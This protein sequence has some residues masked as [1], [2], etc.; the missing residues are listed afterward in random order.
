MFHS[1]VRSVV[2]IPGI[3]FLTACGGGGSSKD[4]DSTAQTTPVSIQFSAVVG[5]EPLACNVDYNAVGTA[6]TTTQ[7][8]DFRLFVHGVQLITDS[9]EAVSLT[10]DSSVW[11]AQ[12]VALLDF[13]NATGE[14]TGTAE[15]NVTVTGIV[16]AT[17]ASFTGVRFT[18]GIPE[19][20]NHLEQ[21]SVSPF[22]VTGM[23]W[24]W[25]NG[26]KFI[27]F[28]VPNWNVHVG[29]TGCAANGSGNVVCTHANRPLIELDNFDYQSQSI[30]IDYAAL[31]QGSD[32]S[33]DA[34]GATGCMS[35]GT[36]PEC[37]DVFTQLGLN[38][39]SGE[40]D[41]ALTQSVFSVAD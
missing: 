12:G 39:A 14:C 13:E 3:V 25:T 32:I 34:G 15:T 8:K 18:V 38:L 35:G 31:V 6:N 22:N 36:D 2:S 9:D 23:N 24:G 20:L 7:I 30:Q 11:Q 16:A 17:E 19:S 10:L 41:S 5:S 26:Y 28:D 1:R 33:T 4:A 27:R 37:Y 40:N 21:T 29:A